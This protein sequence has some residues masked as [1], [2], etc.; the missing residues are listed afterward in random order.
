MTACHKE[1]D[2]DI[3]SQS[4]RR[5]GGRTKNVLCFPGGINRLAE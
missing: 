1:F 2:C 5:F 4:A 3:L